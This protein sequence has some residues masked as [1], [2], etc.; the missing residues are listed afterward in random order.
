M[1]AEYTYQPG[2]VVELLWELVV[3]TSTGNVY[4]YP[5]GTRLIYAG[6]GDG[7]S[8][9]NLQDDEGNVFPNVS[10]VAFLKV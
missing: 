10:T 8:T 5:T 9:A 7:P 3:E 6:P 4:T 1:E 2:D